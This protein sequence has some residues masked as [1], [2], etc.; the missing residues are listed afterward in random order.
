MIRRDT[1]QDTDKG[2]Y[3]S[4]FWI[5]VAMGKDGGQGT[6]ATLSDDD[7]V[8]AEPAEMTDLESLPDL[9]EFPTPE[10]VQPAQPA[11]PAKSKSSEKKPETPRSLN[12]LADLAS[13][14]MMM[15]DSAELGDETEV[16]LAT[17]E[18]ED[19]EVPLTGDYNFEEGAEDNE[20][21]AEGADDLDEFEDEDFE[22]D[23]ED[24]GWG[25]GRKRPSK[26]QKPRRERRQY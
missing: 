22:D 12:S 3:Y 26:P 21:A 4:N 7:I 10:P 15:K 13:I 2:R 6:S 8:M 25:G 17:D 5:E 9:A 24:D 14:D 19:L 1:T 11:K 16:D 23:E 20:V 18:P